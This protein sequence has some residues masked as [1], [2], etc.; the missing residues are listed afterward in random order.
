MKI[1]LMTCELY[2]DLIK[3]ESRL[4]EDFASQGI[5]ALPVVWDK[6]W[7]YSSFDL[8][9]LRSTWDYYKK[10]EIF[11]KWL[12]HLETQGVPLVNPVSTVRWNMDKMYLKKLEESGVNIVPSVF[13]SRGELNRYGEIIQNV[14]WEKIIVKPC[15]SAG[16]W[17]TYLFENGEL[18]V[19]LDML[20]GLSKEYDI[21]IQKFMDT[22][23]REGEFSYIFFNGVFEYAV[24]KKP[25]IGDFRVQE[26]YGGRYV[27]HRPRAE[28]LAVV[29]NLLSKVEHP[30]SYA[31]VDGV[32]EDDFYLM[33]I[34][35]IEP[36]LYLNI[37]PGAY[38]N[39]VEAMIRHL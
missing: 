5:E 10:P 19:K 15:I 29:Q 13:I 27:V 3:A 6:V 23:V 34:E 38:E 22:V 26:K 35:L 17:H 28:E 7:D 4:V 16:S 8:V 33:E 31:R 32:W 20:A 30:H 37:I 1:A 39:Y 9:I 21:V 25:A 24:N 12:S 36:D 2:P 18:P 14:G 11:Y